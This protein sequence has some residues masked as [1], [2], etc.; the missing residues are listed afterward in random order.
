MAPRNKKLF[1]AAVGL[2]LGV[3]LIMGYE[4]YALDLNQ[5]VTI[6]EYFWRITAVHPILAFALGYLSGHLTWQSSS[7]YRD[8]FLQKAS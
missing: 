2:W 8:T 5:G 3:A 4:L 6:S 1:A 7:V